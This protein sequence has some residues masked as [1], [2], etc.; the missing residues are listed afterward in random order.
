MTHLIRAT[1]TAGALLAAATG[2]LTAGPAD[3]APR[4][5]GPGNWLY[6]TVTHGAAPTAG[7]PGTLLLCDPPQGHAQADACAELAAAGGDIRSIPVRHGICPMIYAPVTAQARG[8]WNG[9]SITYQQTFANPCVMSA[10]T[11]TIFTPAD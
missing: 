4:D 9:R 7:T 5:A 10:R 3:A 11:G 6:F 8:R 1:V 2:L